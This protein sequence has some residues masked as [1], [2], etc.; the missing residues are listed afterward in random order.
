MDD[1]NEALGKLRPFQQVRTNRITDGDNP[2]TPCCID[3]ASLVRLKVVVYGQ[4]EGALQMTGQPHSLTKGRSRL[5]MNQIGRV[6]HQPTQQDGSN[7]RSPDGPVEM[8]QL[9][10]VEFAAAFAIKRSSIRT[11]DAGPISTLRQVLGQPQ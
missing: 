6:G 3:P 7:D 11:D 1:R 9:I 5:D 4:D 8:R 10:D 2:S